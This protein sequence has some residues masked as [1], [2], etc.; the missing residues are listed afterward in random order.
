M[1]YKQKCRRCIFKSW[2]CEQTPN[3][4]YIHKS[5]NHPRDSGYDELVWGAE[6][7]GKT[8]PFLKALICF[9]Q[10]VDSHFCSG[11]RFLIS[12]I[13]YCYA[14]VAASVHFDIEL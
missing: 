8:T 1:L 2:C 3:G 4:G 7:S 11:L 9:L 14:S 6:M 12:S 5:T 10:R 13:S